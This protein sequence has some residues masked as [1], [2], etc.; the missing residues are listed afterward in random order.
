M[1]HYLVLIYLYLTGLLTG[2]VSVPSVTAQ[3]FT[4]KNYDVEIAIRKDGSFQVTENYDVAFITQKHGIWRKIPLRYKFST[5]NGNTENRSISVT[6]IDVP[7]WEYKTERGWS[8]LGIK[9][10][11]PDKYVSGNQ[12][13]T[14]KY[15]VDRALIQEDSL[16][17]FYWNL[18]GTEWRAAF[19]KVQFKVT[20]PDGLPLD[21]DSYAVYTGEQ[22]NTTTSAE[23]RYSGGVLSGKSTEE[24]GNGKDMTVLLKLPKG[25]LNIKSES[26]RLWGDYQWLLLLLPLIW[27]YYRIWKK[28]GKDDKLVIAVEYFPPKGIDPV[29]AGYLVN[30]RTDAHDLTSLIPHWGSGGYLTV[31][32]KKKEW[33]LG[34]GDTILRKVKDLP[35]GLEPYQYTI[36]NG[37]FK[38]GDEV[39]ISSLKNNFYKTMELA[40]RDLS[41]VIRLENF[42][43]MKSG[44]LRYVMAILFILLGIAGAAAL[45]YFIGIPAAIIWGVVC[46]VLAILSAAFMRKPTLKGDEAKQQVLGFKMFVQKAE[47]AQLERMLKEDPSYF[48]K[49]LAYA[50]A[51]GMAAKWAGKFNGLDV[52]P[53]GWYSGT[54]GYAAG[55]AFSTA[56]FA[57]SFSRSMSKMSETMV[58]SP[59]SSG[60]GSSGGGFGG[61]GGG[62]W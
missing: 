41:T 54:S 9:I 59:S 45:F 31:T 29:K 6:E 13:Y 53:P 11:D 43:D 20:L 17:A 2:I 50:V 42:Y 35:A 8:N 16:D 7:G 51:F 22:G 57:D 62:S 61:G 36:F 52:P 40:K 18:L 25:Y 10:G 30:D 58:S 14:I 34:H 19:E 24:L 27:F 47:K 46:L 12:H 32:E 21:K 49:T 23:Y 28:F 15:L 1:Q 5:P 38:G 3:D 26:R 48:D 4:V 55:R 37:L 56:A 60:G 39:A 44:A 33:L